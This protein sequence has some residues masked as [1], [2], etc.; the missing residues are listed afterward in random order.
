[1]DLPALTPRTILAND[2]IDDTIT[3]MRQNNAVPQCQKLISS[4][5]KLCKNGSMNFLRA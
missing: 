5:S 4:L 2:T 1:M 3:F